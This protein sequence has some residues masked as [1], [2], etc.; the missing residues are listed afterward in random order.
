MTIISIAN[1]KGGVG[2]STL[3]TNIAGYFAASGHEVCLGDIDRQQSSQ[4]WLGLRPPSIAKIHSWPI[5]FDHITQAPQNCEYAIMDTPAGLHGWRLKEVLNLSDKV[6]VPIQPSIF[7]IFAS[8]EFLNELNQ[9]QKTKKFSLGIVG[10]RID[11]RTIAASKL[12]DFMHA[13]DVPVL[14]FIRDTQYYIQMAAHGFSLFD[15]SASRVQKDLEQWQP[16]IEWLTQK[17]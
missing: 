11:E 8:R 10:M 7:D 6:I 4:L 15:M 9:A 5:N 12:K 14:G 2:K 3:A 13:I 16:I 17:R 1:I